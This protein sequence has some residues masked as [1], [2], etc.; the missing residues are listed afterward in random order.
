MGRVCCRLL[1]LKKLCLKCRRLDLVLD[2]LYTS[3]K[4]WLNAG[5]YIYYYIYVNYCYK[6]VQT[7]IILGIPLDR[8]QFVV[9][10]NK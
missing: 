2:Y 7:V 4:L 1:V 3:K 10:P 8:F 6:N 5:G 9:S